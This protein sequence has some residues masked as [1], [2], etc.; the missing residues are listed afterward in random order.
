M[1]EE[2]FFEQAG[3]WLRDNRVK[4]AAVVGAAIS[5]FNTTILASLQDTNLAE[6]LI[7]DTSNKDLGIIIDSLATG[8]AGFAVTYAALSIWNQFGSRAPEW[9]VE[10]ELSD[11][12][13][14]R[15]LPEPQTELGRHINRARRAL[16]DNISS[17]D[18]I[19]EQQTALE[20]LLEASK[21]FIK[22]KYQ[23]NMGV[24]EIDSRSKYED[25]NK[26][27]PGLELA[28]IRTKSAKIMRLAIDIRDYQQTG[29]Q[30]QIVKKILKRKPAWKVKDDIEGI[31]NHYG[32]TIIMTDIVAALAEGRVDDVLR[33]IKVSKNK[34]PSSFNHL[35]LGIVLDELGSLDDDVTIM[36]EDHWKSTID[37]IMET[38]VESNFRKLKGS[39]NEVLEF[40]KPDLARD[41]IIVK[42]GEGKK[43]IIE[44][45]NKTQFLYDIVDE[46][47][48]PQPLVCREVNSVQYFMQR[49][50]EGVEAIQLLSTTNKPDQLVEKILF[51]LDN[52]QRAVNRNIKKA[53]MYGL[54]FNKQDYNKLIDQKLFSRIEDVLDDTTKKGL[55]K[56]MPA[57]ISLMEQGRFGGCHGDP[58]AENFI[59]D[60]EGNVCIIDHEK[61]HLGVRNT[62]W[63][64]FIIHTKAVHKID[65][66]E[67][68]QTGYIALKKRDAHIIDHLKDYHA[69]CSFVCLRMAGTAHKYWKAGN[70]QPKEYDVQLEIYMEECVK[71]LEFLT[72]TAYC[73]RDDEIKYIKEKIPT[74]LQS[75][76]ASH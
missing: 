73:N 2:D 9:I 38:K 19:P 56:N 14:Y 6:S 3:L 60:E 46:G 40:G 24:A 39:K 48:I 28:M 16:Y 50:K 27:T 17:M 47:L 63:A 52:Y 1:G 65:L 62:D 35:A 72:E 59:V 71:S 25:I 55:K 18:L 32:S 37:I 31:I 69:A 58:H 26:T 42:R 76:S 41:T 5:A 12:Y 11:D 20:H 66:S 68:A 13:I 44:E 8:S 51:A 57:L 64:H 10:G 49:R 53:K 74:I 45:Y 54:E 67:Y 34:N 36:L 33:L 15:T 7:I 29:D 43:Q 75:M 70:L 30:T 23:K 61:L 22:S 21:T 4:S